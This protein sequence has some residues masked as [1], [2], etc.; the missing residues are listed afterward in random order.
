MD[1][2]LK[3][4]FNGAYAPFASQTPTITE[5]LRRFFGENL[6]EEVYRG[7]IHHVDGVQIYSVDLDGMILG[8]IASRD[9]ILCA[10]FTIADDFVSIVN[11][12]SI[13]GR[14]AES[15]AHFNAEAGEDV[16]ARIS[17]TIRRILNNA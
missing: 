17:A 13:V 4:E 9:G 16:N 1:M 3:T 2:L 10:S 12:I 8:W 11:G 15:I 14:Q 5:Q 6:P 7:K